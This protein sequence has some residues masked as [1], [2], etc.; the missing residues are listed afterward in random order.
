MS[1]EVGSAYATLRV[2]LDEWNQGLETAISSLQGY[3][4]RLQVSM[5]SVGK[6]LT[7]AGK[8]LTTKVTLPIVGIGTAAVKTSMDFESAMSKVASLS[9]AQGEQFDSLR[10]KALEMGA[11]TMYSAT[12]SAEAL[13]Y[14]A[15]AGWNTEDMLNGL[16][17][18]LKLAGAAGMDLGTA[19]DIVTDGLTAMGLSA[20]DAAHFADVM[21]V[22][23]SKSNTD[24]NQ[25]GEA[26]KYVAPLAGA[27]GYKIEDLSLALGLMANSG[28]KASQGG[29]SLR[30]VL[31]NLSDPTGE[32]ASA[33][34]DL[35][36]SMFNPDG[37]AKSLYD[38]MVELR[39][40]MRGLSE[41]EQAMY[42]NTIAGST[43]LSGLLAIVNASDED[44]NNLANAIYNADGA[45]MEMYDTMT[46]NLNGSI[47]ELMS[48]LESLMISMGDLLVPLI[49]KVVSTIQG[50][51]EHINSLD[52]TQK[53]QIIQ[54]ALVVAAI[55]PLILI[56]G[57]LFT[58]ISTVVKFVQALTANP[59]LI[60]V[61]AIAA[62]IGGL[63]GTIITNWDK[64]KSATENVWN[65]IKLFVTNVV[66]GLLSF[67]EN[68]FPGFREAGVRLF[69]GLWDGLKSVWTK[70][71]NWVSNGIKTLAELLNPKNWFSD[72]GNPRSGYGRSFAAGLDSVPYD[73]YKVTLHKGE[74]VLTAQ[75][76]KEYN[77]GRAANSG[78]TY[79]F[80]S[81]KAIDVA[82]AKRMLDSV[83]KQQSLGLDLG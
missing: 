9:G 73:G 66:N 70:I 42:A 34:K 55:G 68:L 31:Q 54:I 28:I 57:K 40:S 71:T 60:L 65:G 10:D 80:Y 1:V 59:V 81:P 45:G 16:E 44:F 77:T 19:S 39:G 41:E 13:Q 47:T 35:G 30:R 69:T 72:D 43:G 4:S 63:V 11:K 49:K 50:W 78:N 24:V 36:I 14:M 25:L 21:A 46:N 58:A 32:V 75:E 18:I 8:S 79:N 22:T 61:A 51:V 64:T 3:G 33:M 20:K 15:L 56:V 23:M 7:S 12:E 26:F 37:S 67:I 38:L 53:Q 5:D 17:P 74:R 2:K 62:A 6:K 83:T 27:M 52:E 76:N 29:T 82:Q 48:A